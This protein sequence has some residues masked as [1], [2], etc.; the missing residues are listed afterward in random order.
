MPIGL[1]FIVAPGDPVENR[2]LS[3]GGPALTALALPAAAV[4]TSAWVFLVAPRA[5]GLGSVAAQVLLPFAA[6]LANQRAAIPSA[7]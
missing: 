5:I 6:H 7:R 3:V 2:R 4:T 1:L